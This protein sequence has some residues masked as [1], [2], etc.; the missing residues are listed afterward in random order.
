V[1]TDRIV[2]V[3]PRTVVTANGREHAVDTIVFGPGST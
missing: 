2:E 3:G 1:V